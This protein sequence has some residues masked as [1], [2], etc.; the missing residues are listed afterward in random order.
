MC[1]KE[2]TSREHAPPRCIFPERSDTP[3]GTDY[4]K[5]LITVPSCDE[6]NSEKS[7][8]DEYL[9][10]ALAGSYTSSDVGLTQFLTKVKRAF[11]HR[12]SKA[13]SFIRRS[14][15]VQ[16]R[17]VEQVDWEDGLQVIVDGD[18]IDSVLSNCGRALYFHETGRKFMGQVQVF[19]HFTMYNDEGLQANITEA[20]EAAERIFATD[21]PRGA[22]PDVFWYKFQETQATAVFYMSFFRQSTAMVRFSKILVT[23]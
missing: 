15:P 14:A 19:T 1:P 4:R 12:P 21:H 6:H 7:H 20:F 9:L 3:S 23:K 11:E 10:F 22:N 16:L 18:R 13:E 17:R 8:D 2:A 5:N